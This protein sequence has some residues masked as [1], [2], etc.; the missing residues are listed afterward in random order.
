[1]TSRAVYDTP[2]GVS[3]SI[4]ESFASDHV[5]SLSTILW[6]VLVFAF[7]AIQVFETHASKSA[8]YGP[9]GLR[10]RPTRLPAWVTLLESVR[11]YPLDGTAKRKTSFHLGPRFCLETPHRTRRCLAATTVTLTRL[12]NLAFHLLTQ[13]ERILEINAL[14]TGDQKLLWRP[15][16]RA[17]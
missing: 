3:S 13:M 4:I 10:K 5:V 17:W 8:A 2:A 15:R 16:A 9:I 7:P 6:T 1:M 14:P 11:A 12:S